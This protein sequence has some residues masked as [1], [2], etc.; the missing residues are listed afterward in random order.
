MKI[1][2]IEPTHVIYKKIGG[3]TGDCQRFEV[4]EIMPE[5]FEVKS[6]EKSKPKQCSD[7]YLGNDGCCDGFAFYLI[8]VPNGLFKQINE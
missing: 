3:F 1:Q 8:N 2:F 4:K 5:I 6:I 7:I